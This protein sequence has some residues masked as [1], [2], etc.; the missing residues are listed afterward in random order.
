MVIHVGAVHAGQL[1]RIRS[2][3]IPIIPSY[4]PS[5][6]DTFEITIKLIWESR[7]HPNA[8]RTA[9]ADSLELIGNTSGSR[10]QALLSHP[11]LPEHGETGI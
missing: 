4:R 1:G 9:N 10:Q 3:I 5:F 7:I 8:H 11:A 6:R 2:V